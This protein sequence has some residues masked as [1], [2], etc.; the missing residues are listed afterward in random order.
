MSGQ[1]AAHTDNA[2]FGPPERRRRQGGIDV[3]ARVQ[4]DGGVIIH[5][6]ARARIE[7]ALD[8]LLQAG[9]LTGN[10][11]GRRDRDAIARTRYEAGLSLRRLFHAAG[12]TGV[13]AYDPERRGGVSEPSDAQTSAFRRYNRIIRA[14][15]DLAPA[16]TAPC[17]HDSIATAAAQRQAVA[18]GL[19]RLCELLDM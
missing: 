14:L 4:T 18:R 5:R 13:H 11:G 17:C 9:V 15:G 19:D 10:Q 1:A 6:G 8:A 2:D 16:V 3:G 12:L 7:C